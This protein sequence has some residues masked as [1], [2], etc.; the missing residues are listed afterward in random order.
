MPDVHT[1]I[2]V[3]PGGFT[4]L[5][6]V[7]DTYLTA[8]ENEHPAFASAARALRYLHDPANS[9]AV[10]K[11]ERRRMQVCLPPLRATIEAEYRRAYAAVVQA[12]QDEDP[13]PPQQS[14][15]FYF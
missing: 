8:L 15:Q 2:W 13:I 6:A 1:P 5:P 3:H 7:Y 11:R 10:A 14:L 12:E 4:D 9:R